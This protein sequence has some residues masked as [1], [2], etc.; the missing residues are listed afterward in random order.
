MLWG[1]PLVYTALILA[2]S[3]IP[4]GKTP[5]IYKHQDKVLHFVEYAILS[6]LLYRAFLPGLGPVL[7][8]A[9]CIAL[10]S[11]LG[12]AVEILQPLFGRGA[13]FLDFTADAA[14]SVAAAFLAAMPG[15]LRAGPS[16]AGPPPGGEPT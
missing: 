2:A 13:D 6:A 8:M 16:Q 14:G 10:S 7:S 9:A 15:L 12:G 3:L 11:A 5:A 4:F 1:P